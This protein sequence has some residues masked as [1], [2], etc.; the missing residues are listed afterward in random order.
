MRKIVIAMVVLM[1]FSASVLASDTR[2]LTM[3]ENNMVLIDDA[4]IW[5]FPSRVFEY[6]N[7]AVGEFGVNDDFNQLGVH[8]KFGS[9]NPL[10]LG[11][12][13]TV[14]PPISPSNLAG[15]AL[16]PF[17]DLNLD[18]RRIDFFYGNGLANFNYGSRFSIYHSS[19]SWDDSA[20][21]VDQRK[22]SFSYYDLAFGLTSQSGKWDL[23]LNI[24]FGSW[25]D[26]AADGATESE[27]D[28]YMD[29]AVVGR[30]FMQRGPNYTFIPHAAIVSGKHGIKFPDV[31]TEKYSLTGF[32]FG[33]GVNY[34]PASDV[35]AV[36]DF[37]FAYS[38]WKEE[39]EDLVAPATMEQTETVMALPYFKIGF[40]ADV[41][42]WMDIRMGA[43]SYWTSEKHD[44]QGIMGVT[45]ERTSNYADNETYLGFGFHWKRLHVDTYTDPEMFLQGFDFLTGNGDVDMNFRISAVYEML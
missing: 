4:N 44:L 8:W 1:L 28:G 20:P 12:Y 34:T 19:V 18:N 29:F 30:Y 38:K 27:A 22:E 32:E 25:T 26:E 9:D 36:C 13:F 7:I 37:G 10:V 33:L 23:A 24:G 14:L 21:A 41:F 35:L 31:Q 11:T 39:I 5:L 40:D 17:D 16:V 15:D 2:V 42:K 45:G 6:P 3:G 43:T